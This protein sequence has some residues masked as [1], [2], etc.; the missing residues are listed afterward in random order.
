[1]A[2]NNVRLEVRNY[3]SFGGQG[4]GFDKIALFNIIVGRNNTGKSALIDIIEYACSLK[5]T[6][7][8]QW[9]KKERSQIIITAQLSEALL[10]TAFLPNSSGGPIRMG[11]THWELVGQRLIGV[12]I[13]FTVSG[14]KPTILAFDV[15]EI[16]LAHVNVSAFDK[17]VALPL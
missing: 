16:A 2:F 4:A 15:P 10:R 17:G 3:K 7:Q 13:S 5:E 12:P 6:N 1:M 9:H 11:G 14:S 8:A